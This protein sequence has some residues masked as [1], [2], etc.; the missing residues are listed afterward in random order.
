M[1]AWTTSNRH[2]AAVRNRALAGS[3]VAGIV[4][5][6]GWRRR[7]LTVSGAFAGWFTGAAVSAAG[8]DCA[9]AMLAFFV[10]GSALSQF[11]G[12]H[13]PALSSVWEKGGRRDVAQVAANGGVAV[14][15]AM[16]HAWRPGGLPVAA[17]MGALAAT[18]ADTWATEIGVRSR[19][20]PRRITDGRIVPKGM[21]GGVT[22]LGFGGGLAGAAFLAGIASTMRP[23]RAGTPRLLSF[24]GFALAGL[25]GSV[26]DSLL[27][28][29][30]QASR[31]CP[32]CRQ[33]TE[34]RIHRCGTRT[35]VTRGF[36]WL[37]NDAVNAAATIVGATVA[38]LW[39]RR[40]AERR[41]T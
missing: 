41:A 1:A 35:R 19:A 22:A 27:G 23:R 11:P 32:A 28:A 31:M 37:D 8:W 20:A 7:A 25:A 9:A 36:A 17:C 21:S 12:G 24:A 4:A 18:T 6:L 2:G 33:A 26:F 10:S 14:L 16:V 29:A 40:L 38:M 30:V 3:V 5:W 13:D 34:R 15:A 39:Q